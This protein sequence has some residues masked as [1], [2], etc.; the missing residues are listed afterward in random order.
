M[1]YPALDKVITE[2]NTRF[3]E[4]NNIV[5]SYLIFVIFDADPSDE[6]CKTLPNLTS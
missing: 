3:S 4:N 1:F 2:L 5:L 6:S